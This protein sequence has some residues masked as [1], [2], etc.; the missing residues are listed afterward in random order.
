MRTNSA[1][2]YLQIRAV[3]FDNKSSERLLLF[4]KMRIRENL[5]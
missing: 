5:K 2:T 4:F 1:T 3:V